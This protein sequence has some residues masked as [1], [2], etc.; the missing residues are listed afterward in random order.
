MLMLKRITP[1]GRQVGRNLFRSGQ[2]LGAH[3]SGVIE[4][5]MGAKERE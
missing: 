5:I 2:L 1:S 4:V 3:D